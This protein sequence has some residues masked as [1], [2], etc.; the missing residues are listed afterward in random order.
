MLPIMLNFREQ[1]VDG[2]LLKLLEADSLHQANLKACRPAVRPVLKLE[3]RRNRLHYETVHR[4]WQCHLRPVLFSDESRL[5][6]DFHDGRRLLW[7]SKG[8]K[9]ADCSIYEEVRY[10]GGLLMILA[11][12]RVDYK[13][14]LRFIEG[15]LTGLKN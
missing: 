12:I 15:S 1:Q 13:T 5:C 2:S 10:R 3:H 8:E 9:L 4:K 7:R 14:D 6:V 11:G